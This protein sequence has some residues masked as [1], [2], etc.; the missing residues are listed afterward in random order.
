MSESFL[1]A[2]AARAADVGAAAS[3]E[4]ERL[5]SEDDE[6]TDP[7]DDESDPEAALLMG[8]DDE[9]L[10]MR[11]MMEELAAMGD[12]GMAESLA[13]A[14]QLQNEEYEN[15]AYGDGNYDDDEGTDGEDEDEDEDNDANIDVDAMSYEELLELGERI[16]SVNVG[17]TEAQVRDVLV[18]LRDASAVALAQSKSNTCAVCLEAFDFGSAVP[19]L[20]PC[21]PGWRPDLRPA[22]LGCGHVFHAECAR[23]H[24]RVT[25]ACP[26]C[27]TE[28]CPLEAS[29]AR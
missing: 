4:D 7:E 5:D 20:R 14:L 26:V 6:Q 8:D 27:R 15:L 3:M 11:M 22:R 28:A 19:Q 23:Q 13:L 16:G 18:P 2:A 25:R 29:P 9:S 24:L 21:A 17:A 12:S 1:A 10:A